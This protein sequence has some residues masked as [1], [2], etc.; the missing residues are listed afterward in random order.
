MLHHY[1]R[2][3]PGEKSSS[4]ACARSGVVTIMMTNWEAIFPTPILRTNIDRA[5]TEK[6]LK[7]FRD[8]QDKA[9]A[10]VLNSR[11]MDTNVLDAAEMRPVR[12]FID[13]HVKQF[14]RKTI[15]ISEK[16]EFYVTQSWVNFTRPGQ[17]HHRHFHTNSLVSGVLYI[18]AVREIDKIWF[19]RPPASGICVGNPDSNWY[20]ADSWFFSVGTGDLVLFPSS[21]T[22]GVEETTGQHVRASL[23]F[24]TFVKGEIGERDKLNGLK[25][26]V[27]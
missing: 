9:C 18:N 21:L 10:N 12:S 17:A 19:H 25:L 27:S 1:M 14:C 11:S 24:N 6:E 26:N 3:G 23:S 8:A 20:T 15:S 2:S 16:L 22:H 4:G 13:E 5:F 7:F